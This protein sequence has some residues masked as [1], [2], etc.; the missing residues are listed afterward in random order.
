MH[1]EGRR[2]L[3]WH[4]K[5]S[6]L[7]TLHRMDV[8]AELSFSGLLKSAKRHHCSSF[9]HARSLLDC[10]QRQLVDLQVV[11]SARTPSCTVGNH[12]YPAQAS[13]CGGPVPPSSKPHLQSSRSRTFHAK[14]GSHLSRRA[15][16][17]IIEAAKATQAAVTAAVEHAAMAMSKRGDQ[18]LEASPTRASTSKS[19]PSCARPSPYTQPVPSAK[20]IM[21][22]LRRLSNGTMSLEAAVHQL[23]LE[24]SGAIA[25]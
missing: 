6:L 11:I 22:V 20:R 4:V 18:T 5:L 10:A 13:H 24:T 2:S 14:A 15:S 7:L 19:R 1:C 17:S 3:P 16:C 12:C 9:K 25:S 8:A 21:G 23:R